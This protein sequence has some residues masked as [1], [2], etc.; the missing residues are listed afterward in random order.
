M[1]SHILVPLTLSL[2]RHQTL[3]LTPR[4]TTV[5]MG[6]TP[7]SA[8]ALWV[9]CREALGASPEY[10]GWPH[11]EELI[12]V[13]HTPAAEVKVPALSNAGGQKAGT[14]DVKSASTN[15]LCTSYYTGKPHSAACKVAS[16]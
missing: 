4:F 15:T 14:L 12:I 10:P 6:Q 8:T 5:E 16:D 13:L 9:G 3:G 1:P 11:N 7:S 2:D